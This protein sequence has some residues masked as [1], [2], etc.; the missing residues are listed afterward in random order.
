MTDDR[1]AIGGITYPFPK[2]QP[3]NHWIWGMNNQ[4]HPTVYWARDY[5]S[6]L[7]SKL[8]HISKRGPS[9]YGS[10]H[11]RFM[12]ALSSGNTL[13][14]SSDID[15]WVQKL[16]HAEIKVNPI[17]KRGSFCPEFCKIAVFCALSFWTQANRMVWQWAETLVEIRETLAD[18]RGTT[19]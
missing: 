7:R 4:L 9:T 15:H 1:P 19:K 3:S 12:G 18:I 10:A 14:S 13:V 11:M 16:I 6:I 2:L 5:L 8:I 17:N